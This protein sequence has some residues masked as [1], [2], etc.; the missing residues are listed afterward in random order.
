[1]PTTLGGIDKAIEMYMRK[2]HIGKT[3]QQKLL[4]ERELRNFQTT[5][6]NLIDNDAFCRNIVK[7]IQEE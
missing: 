7:I 6:Q 4:E 1:M 3:S 5:L 2:G